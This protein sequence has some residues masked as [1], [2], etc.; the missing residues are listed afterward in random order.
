MKLK[1]WFL[2]LFAAA[3]MVAC[4]GGGEDANDESTDETTEETTT[5]ETEDTEDNSDDPLKNKGIGPITSV[6]LGDEIDETM[7]KKG[8]EVFK[9]TC[10]ACHDL[11]TDKIGPA[12]GDVLEKRSPEWV[13]NMT[14]NTKEMEEKDPLAKEAKAKYNSAMVVSITEEEARGVVEYLR[15]MKK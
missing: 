5:D 2:A 4:S 6:D 8:E 9:S 12:L 15:S 14:L 7:A 3:F 13:M 1:Y 11:N 10:S